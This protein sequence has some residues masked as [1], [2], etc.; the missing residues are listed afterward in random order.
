LDIAL[1]R[2]DEADTGGRRITPEDFDQIVLRHQ[3]R[4]FRIL[5]SLVRDANAAD[6]LTQE[7]FLRAFRKR[8]DF[9]GEAG[10]A[11]WIV[12]IAINLAR[13]H[14]RSR[15]MI[16]WRRLERTDRIERVRVVDAGPSPEKALADRELWDA[17]RSAVDALPERQRTVFLLRFVEEM[18]LDEIAEATGLRPGTVKTH[19]FRALAAVRT[20][21]GR[22]EVR[23]IETRE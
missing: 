11:T 8:G 9:R 18:P 15:R 4:I 20:A 14:N 17:V 21:C 22:S 10:I 7:C 2:F 19:L 16:F 5:L 3:R 12:R 13:D 1:T 6:T 23:E